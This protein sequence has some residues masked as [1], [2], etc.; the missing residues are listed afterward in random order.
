MLSILSLFLMGGM[1]HAAS[2]APMP[3]Q[4]PQ[5][6]Q[7]PGLP[8]PEELGELSQEELEELDRMGREFIKEMSEEDLKEF[9]DLTGI[10]FEEISEL[11]REIEQEEEPQPAPAKEK[12]QEPKKP[13]Q[14][15]QQQP[16]KEQYIQERQAQDLITS[17]INI[18]ETLI[19]AP[20][21][22]AERYDHLSSFVNNMQDLKQYLMI[23]RDKEHVRRLTSVDYKH[24]V[25]TLQSLLKQLE[26][27]VEQVSMPEEYIPSYYEKLGVSPGSSQEEIERAYQELKQAYDPDE[28][29]RQL[30]QDNVPPRQIDKRVRAAQSQFMEIKEAY[31]ALK[32][33]RMREQIERQ[34]QAQYKQYQEELNRLEQAQ[35]E[36]ATALSS[37]TYDN[38]LLEHLSSFVKAYEPRALEK[39][40]ELEAQ[41]AERRKEQQRR[42]Q[43]RPVTTPAGQLE[44]RVQ[45]PSDK[46]RGQQQRIGTPNPQTTTEPDDEAG[47]RKDEQKPQQQE[48]NGAG[49]SGQQQQQEKDSKD[50]DGKDKKSQDTQKGKR[51][52]QDARQAIETMLKA[53]EAVSWPQLQTIADEIKNA[54]SLSYPQVNTLRSLSNQLSQ[55]YQQ[56]KLNQL[57]QYASKLT[58]EAS[59]EQIQEL[60]NTYLSQ[61]ENILTTCRDAYKKTA[62]NVAIQ[63]DASVQEIQQQLQTCIDSVKPMY[64]ALQAGEKGGTSEV[65]QLGEH[66]NHLQQKYQEHKRTLGTKLKASPNMLQ[67]AEAR[68]IEKAAS[69]ITPAMQAIQD[70]L[71]QTR[72]LSQGL[73]QEQQQIWTQHI[74]TDQL[75][76]LSSIS[77]ATRQAYQNWQQ[78]DPNS[79][80]TQALAQLQAALP[81]DQNIQ[82]LQQKTQ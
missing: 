82:A 65:Q 11:K 43:A 46:R 60:S 9:S 67:P 7:P 70:A 27:H 64:D 73:T 62:G 77:Y 26:R 6:E 56:G 76:T 39:K 68:E 17:L 58:Q 1:L 35:K 48:G 45:Q 40:Q 52:V 66:L 32:D 12:P 78:H 18:L 80:V 79:S 34:Q 31:N 75:D 20:E 14:E 36:I 19:Q 59:Q 2:P 42:A 24:I 72:I 53:Q 81:S 54:S 61:I 51:S 25:T 8:S 28:I 33:P 74:T 37:A 57:S 44:P 49:G 10:P 50:K 16:Q 47:R 4:E 30:K 22:L 71:Q 63:Q 13:E 69:D 21:T 41:E 55:F 23:I 38:K 15:Q 3:P 5:Q 29:R